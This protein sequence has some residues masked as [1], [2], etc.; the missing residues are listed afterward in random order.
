MLKDLPCHP[1]IAAADLDRARSFYEGTLGFEPE[2]VAPGGVFYGTRGGHF[3][4]FPSPGAGTAQNTVMGFATD[5]IEGEVRALKDRGVQ[6][7]EYDF[8]GLKTVDAI[9]TV[10]G[11]RAAW[12][13]DSEGNILG[14][15]QLDSA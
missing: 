14:V 1:T 13:R 10:P 6:F 3:L 12:F 4:L 15:V 5:D 11:L 9:A 2:S 8:P 7:E